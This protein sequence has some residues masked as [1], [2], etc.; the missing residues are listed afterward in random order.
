MRRSSA[1]LRPYRWLFRQ[2]AVAVCAFLTPVFALLYFF[3]VPNGPWRVVLVTQIVATVAVL[4]TTVLYVRVGIWVDGAGITERGFFGRL[5]TVH[6][7]EIGSIVLVRTYQGGGADTVAQL[8]VC[9][10]QGKQ[11]LRMRG[12]FWS[13][14]SMMV[15]S[16][17]LDVPVREI[18][19]S[20]TT[21]ELLEE[22]P[23]LLYWFER[24]PVLAG[25][26]FSLCVVVGG[27]ALYGSLMLLGISPR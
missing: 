2:G 24:R 23:G 18:T 15:V 17:L 21:R 6:S 4:V 27:S 10:Q 25:A 22:Y 13:D 14:Q 12:Q 16:E 1:R 9:D 8:F 11:V 3:T 26:F 19:E 7:P 20:V 5:H